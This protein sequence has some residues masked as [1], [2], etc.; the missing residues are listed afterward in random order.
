MHRQL[1]DA[2]KKLLAEYGTKDTIRFVLCQG[3]SQR[4]WDIFC[5]A[6]GGIDGRRWKLREIACKYDMSVPR[7]SM[8]ITN[9]LARLRGDKSRR[10]KLGLIR[11]YSA[12]MR[13]LL[14][15]NPIVNATTVGYLR[16]AW[17]T[18]KWGRRNCDRFYADYSPDRCRI[19]NLIFYA[20]G[21]QWR[22]V[23]LS[24]MSNGR[25][26]ELIIC[27]MERH[28]VEDGYQGRWLFV[29]PRCV[30]HADIVFHCCSSFWVIDTIRSIEKSDRIVYGVY[31]KPAE[32]AN[33][34][35][36]DVR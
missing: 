22:G 20:Q 17:Q 34:R 5:L 11:E 16:S 29:E 24:R 9:V 26:G 21:I 25:G 12:K 30:V 4:N 27:W 7:V 28:K 33:K 1:P 31:L 10:T 6:E 18:Y 35:R 32:Y 23:S 3:V 14:L 13:Q 2:V 36:L 19:C 8:I 15:E